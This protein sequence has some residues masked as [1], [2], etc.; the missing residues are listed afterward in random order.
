MKSRLLDA[1]VG[2]AVSSLPRVGA[3]LLA[4][5]TAGKADTINV[6]AIVD[7]TLAYS[8]SSSTGTLAPLGFFPIGVYT[9]SLKI[10]SETSLAAPDVLRT[11][12]LNINQTAGG[13]H[14]LIIDIGAQGLSGPN[15]LTNWLSTFSVSGLTAG[16]SV[17]EQTFIN[18]VLLADT[19]VLTAASVSAFTDAAAVGG[20]FNAE[21]RYIINSVGIGNF[22]GGI[23]ISVTD[24]SV[25]AVP[26]PATWSMMILGFAGVGF[27]AYRASRSQR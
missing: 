11:N 27:M 26:E 25:A 23:D 15:A 20:L 2:A 22:S 3:V 10:F 24:I 1:L 6:V 4:L 7:G 13:I 12:T 17:Q 21:V 19:G 14:Q 8:D 9:T 16:W 18:G 5:T